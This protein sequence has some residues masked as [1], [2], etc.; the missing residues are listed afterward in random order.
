MQSVSVVKNADDLRKLAEEMK[1]HYAAL[2]AEFAIDEQWYALSGDID[3]GLPKEYA[4]QG[5]LLPTARSLVDTAVDHISPQFRD[6]TVPRKSASDQATER[7][8]RQSRFYGAALTWLEMQSSSSPYRMAN[9]Q[10]A[11]YGMSVSKTTYVEDWDVSK[12]GGT[13][14]EKEENDFIRS[15]YMPF[16]HQVLHPAEVYPDPFNEE[17]QWVIQ[18][19]DR[20]IGDLRAIYGNFNTNKKLTQ[21]AEVIEYWGKKD[22]LVLVDG[23]TVIDYTEHDLGD[24]PYIIGDSG[25]GFISRDRKPEHRYMGYLRFLRSVLASES[26]NYSI[27]D[28]VLKASGW[29][30]RTASGPGAAQLAGIKLDYGRIHELPEGT[31]LDAITPLLPEN[32]LAAHRFDTSTI[33]SEASAPRPLAG[34]RNPGTTS[35]RDQNIQLGQARLRYQG[36]AQASEMMLTQLARKLGTY[37]QYAVEHP[38]NISLGT[39]EQEYGEVSPRMFKGSRPVKVTVNVLEPDNEFGKKQSVAQEIQAGTLDR[40]NGIRELHPNLDPADVLRGIR[41][42]RL[43][44]NPRVQETL[45]TIT[46]EQI[47]EDENLR[48]LFEQVIE[49]AQQQEATEAASRAGAAGPG[50]DVANNTGDPDLQDASQRGSESS[51]L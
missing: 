43:E 2:H 21:N 46:A 35:G 41:K 50:R 7:A 18:I 32:V 23:E 27:T 49:R 20:K 22:R 33:I 36:M 17:P 26:R 15:E 42:D 47:L 40:Y 28:I 48:D 14:E 51:P 5:T 30:V 10:L 38:V 6:I 4:K 31:T 12:S 39:T 1:A 11:I 25:L 29:P 45:G 19:N 37:M 9:K 34:L 24:H 16:K 3:I 13:E 8:S 44:L